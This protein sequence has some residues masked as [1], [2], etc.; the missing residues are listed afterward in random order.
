MGF[1]LLKEEGLARSAVVGLLPQALQGVSKKK[2]AEEVRGQ[3]TKREI[4]YLNPL[5]CSVSWGIR[6]KQK[7]PE[8]EA[9]TSFVSP[10]TLTRKPSWLT[11]VKKKERK[12][13]LRDLYLTDTSSARRGTYT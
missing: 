9:S 1:L 10:P 8:N 11:G 13:N 5:F 7:P 6:G 3:E 12:G 4:T 2:P